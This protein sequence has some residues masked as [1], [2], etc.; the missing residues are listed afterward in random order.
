MESLH[1]RINHGIEY[2][3]QHPSEEGERYL[4]CLAATDL[5]TGHILR[6]ARPENYWY[7]E[8]ALNAAQ[9][10]TGELDSCALVDNTTLVNAFELLDP[11]ST[12][13]HVQASDIFDL[14]T[15]INTVVFEENLIYLQNE[16]VTKQKINALFDNL[17]IV[18]LPWGQEDDFSLMIDNA[19]GEAERYT[20]DLFQSSP[21]DKQFIEHWQKIT[22]LELTTDALLWTGDYRK[23]FSSIDSDAVE[24]TVNGN[25]YPSES[26]F[27]HLNNYKTERFVT[28]TSVRTV[29]YTLLSNLTNVSYHSN[30]YRS[31]LQRILFESTANF[32]SSDSLNLLN[33]INDGFYSDIAKDNLLSAPIQLPFALSAALSG[34]KTPQDFIDKIN[35]LR[36][37]AGPLRE[38]K[39][40][41]AQAIRDQDQAAV[42]AINKAIADNAK[43]LS[44]H[45]YN[46]GN[47][48]V[49][50]K[51]LS[52][53][54][55]RPIFGALGKLLLHFAVLPK[56]VKDVLRQRTVRPELWI[57][58]DISA[59]ARQATECLPRLYQLLEC[60]GVSV[61]KKDRQQI[62]EALARFA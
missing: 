20:P 49:A 57:L 17:N 42:T 44:E 59:Q 9:Q 56:D 30:A 3:L 5:G 53:G 26:Y 54:G 23:Y 19:W 13:A 39:N 8:C 51:L 46:L 7:K 61:D 52:P 11:K 50:K 35:E 58:S 29:F 32:V 25:F 55:A 6:D 48:M 31:K 24:E 12:S 33:H 28:E 2:S 10:Y 1:K 15:V 37:L 4:M 60:K 38:R 47:G 14:A 40:E 43:S 62:R 36:V 18:E 21:L 45:K 22:G 16:K 34:T 27:S 41:L